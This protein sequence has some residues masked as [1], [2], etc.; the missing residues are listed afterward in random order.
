MEEECHGILILRLWIL[1]SPIENSRE[2]HGLSPERGR[3]GVHAAQLW[4]QNLFLLEVLPLSSLS[5]LG[6]GGQ[7]HALPDNN[8]Q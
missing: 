8:S 5:L 2:T 7:G 3:E 6:G 1:I 4:H